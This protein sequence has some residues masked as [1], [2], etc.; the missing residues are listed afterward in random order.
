[1]VE[2]GAIKAND[3]VSLVKTGELVRIV[4]RLSPDK[5]NLVWLN[6]ELGYV[7]HTV[8]SRQRK[9]YFT[10]YFVILILSVLFS[11]FSRKVVKFI[12]TIKKLFQQTS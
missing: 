8:K 1:M 2:F 6:I 11:L 12:E 7:N 4:T 3:K 10:H 5:K 9:K